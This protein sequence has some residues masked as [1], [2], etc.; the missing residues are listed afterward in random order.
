M[1][2][3]YK[4]WHILGHDSTWEAHRYG[5]RLRA[6]SQELLCTMIDLRKPLRIF[7]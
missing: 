6:N 4:D 2:R 1:H 3:F 7:L 5:V